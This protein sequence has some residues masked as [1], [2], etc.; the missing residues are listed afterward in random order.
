MCI[1]QKIYPQ[2]AVQVVDVFAGLCGSGEDI[3]NVVLQGELPKPLYLLNGGASPL[4][5]VA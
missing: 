3:G 2:L 1:I 4:V 5:R